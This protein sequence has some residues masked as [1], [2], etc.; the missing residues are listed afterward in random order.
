MSSSYANIFILL[1]ILFLSTGCSDKRTELKKIIDSGE[2]RFAMIE[3][4]TTFFNLQPGNTG[5]EYELA[6]AFSERIGIKLKPIITPYEYAVGPLVEK[7]KVNIGSTGLAGTYVTENLRVSPGYN[8]AAYQVVYRYAGYQPASFDDIRY[9]DLNISPVVQQ[10]YL[11]KEIENKHPQFSWLEHADKNIDMLFAMVNQREIVATVA[12][13]N[14]VDIYKHFYPDLRVAFDISEPMPQVW[15]YKKHDDDSLHH[16]IFEYFM[17]IKNNGKL[18]KLLERYF[19]HFDSFDYVDTRIYLNRIEKRLPAYEELFKQVAREHNLKWTL[20]A[21]QSYQESHWNPKARSPTGVRGLM[22]LTQDTAKHVEIDDRLDPEQSITGGALYLNQIYKKIPVQI[23]EPDRTW[24]ALAAY[25]VGIE[26]LEDARRITQKQGGNPDSWF[27]VR[28][29]LPL[30]SEE[31]WYKQTRYGF[32][33]G[34]EPVTY[35]ENIRRY[36]DILNW[37]KYRNKYLP[38]RTRR[39]QAISIDSPVL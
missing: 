10:I 6:K 35:V 27:D 1:L 7:G 21:A 39:R 36:S 30:L 18:E 11:M 9:G 38:Q 20:L 29:R 5:F 14:M 34:N 28:E 26:H 3:G 33:R 22:M 23:R 32:A 17:E 12:D 2:L 4:P 24:F 19:G 13:S 31:E 37:V 8:T 15:I 16:A 25:N